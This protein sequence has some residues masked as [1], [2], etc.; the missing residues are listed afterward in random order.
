MNTVW[1]LY[2]GSLSTG[3]QYIQPPTDSYVARRAANKSKQLPEG[4]KVRT[5]YILNFDS[6]P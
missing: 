4:G 5:L 3:I 6:Q 1:S 2:L